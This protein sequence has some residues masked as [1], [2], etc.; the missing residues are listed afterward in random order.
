MESPSPFWGEICHPPRQAIEIVI[1]S[2]ERKLRR[3]TRWI[4]RAICGCEACGDRASRRLAHLERRRQEEA[5]AGTAK[6]PVRGFEIIGCTMLST[7]RADHRNNTCSAEVFLRF[8]NGGADAAAIAHAVAE[9]GA[10]EEYQGVGDLL[11][12]R[13][14]FSTDTS[15]PTASSALT[16]CRSRARLTD[17]AAL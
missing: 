9:G 13:S 11:E 3:W 17:H 4:C 5:C 10:A 15:A 7:Q 1:A 12:Q 6:R 16:P 2:G 8:F 14:Y